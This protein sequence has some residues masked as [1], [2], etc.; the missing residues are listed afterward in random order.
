MK[1]FTTNMLRKLNFAYNYV[2]K[3]EFLLAV[4][5]T[6]IVVC[7]G[8]F[9]AHENNKVVPVSR[10]SFVHYEAEPRNGLSF[11]SE[12][13][14]P[15]YISIAQHG[16]VTKNETN[17]FPMYPLLIRIFTLL[18]RSSLDSAL[19]ISWLSLIGAIYFYLKIAKHIF[20]IKDN[21][22]ALRAVLLFILF[23]TSVFMIATYTESLFAFLALA[24]VY[25][26]LRKRYIA[27]GLVLLPL[28]A[29]H[30]NGIFVLL[31]VALI[32][33]QQKVKLQN[34]C[35][36][37]A[38]GIVGLVG[39]VVY[40]GVAFHQPLAFIFAQEQ[41]GWLQNNYSNLYGQFNYINITLIILMLI[42]IAYWWKNY[43]GFSFY[44]ACYLFVP[45]IGGQIG[46]F[47]RYSLMAFPVQ[48]ML[49]KKF[50]NSVLAYTVI[51]VLTTII[52]MHFLFQY[53]GGYVGG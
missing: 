4:S 27:S 32:L 1:R 49:Y 6:L 29:T 37:V 47:N 53:A 7:F 31:L 2:I 43:K 11:L 36:T 38:T 3:N 23:P 26:A 8:V 33:Y 22:E 48:L 19:A 17:F 35:V 18:I 28:T 25:C 10:Q 15:D 40:L 42:A 16:Y 14:G 41:H 44:V 39:Y 13:D 5:V 9:L 45:L 21:R 50:R 12:W 34:I 46:G 20:D 51:I 52:C 24:A 30:T